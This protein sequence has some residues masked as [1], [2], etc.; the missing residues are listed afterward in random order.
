[1]TTLCGPQLCRRL[2]RILHAAR[3]D[4]SADEGSGD[5]QGGGGVTHAV[6]VGALVHFLVEHTKPKIFSALSPASQEL[7]LSA[8]RVLP[9]AD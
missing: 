6:T 3:T 7:W 1:M 4:W 9:A 8:L 2:R 5:G